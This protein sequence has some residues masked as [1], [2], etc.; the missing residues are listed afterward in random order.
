[1]TM[2][3]TCTLFELTPEEALAGATREGARALGLQD[4]VGTLEVGK[5]C[6]LAIWNVEEPAALAYA[7]GFNPLQS[8]VWHGH[9]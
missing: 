3:M 7:M 9:V 2:N 1:M 6:D 4:E 8:R 5:W